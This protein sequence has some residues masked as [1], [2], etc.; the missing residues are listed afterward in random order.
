V[1]EDRQAVLQAIAF[2]KD[3]AI[4]PSERLKAIELLGQHGDG[5]DV[6]LEL[7]RRLQALTGE[8]LRA[9]EDSTLAAVILAASDDER[10][11]RW[12]RTCEVLDRRVEERARELARNMA[13]EIARNGFVVHDGGLAETHRTTRRVDETP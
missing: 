8:E 3:R 10:R 12:P 9:E 7:H 13:V 1:N 5:I 11:I 4:R 2:G 6:D